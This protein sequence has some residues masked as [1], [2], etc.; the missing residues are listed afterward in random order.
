MMTEQL[1]GRFPGPRRLSIM[2]GLAALALVV[3]VAALAD[4]CTRHPG[5]ATARPEKSTIV[6]GIVPAADAAGLYIAQ[7]RGLFAA[8]NLHVKIVNIL[9][10]ENAVRTQ[11]AGGYDVT[12]GDYVSYIEA[13][14][15]QHAGLR[16]LAEGSV[17]QPGNQ[18]IV[19]L[20]GSRITSLSQ[21]RGAT[22]AVNLRNNIGTI[23]VDEALEDDGISLAAV[24]LVQVP[25]PQMIRALVR[26]EVDAAWMP[27][28]FLSVAEEQIGAR[29]IADLDQGGAASMPVVGYAV[30]RAWEQKYPRT[31]AAFT[32]ALEKAQVIADTERSEVERVTQDFL[33]VPPLT[34]TVMSIPQYPLGVDRVRLQRIADATLQFDMLKERLD[35]SQM[36]SA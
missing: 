21:L 4:G 1:R 19:T 12:I 16:I 29:E 30:T 24:R 15:E 6:V 7:Q 18:V 17:I 20:P 28:P 13:D 10:P 36:T 25:F 26:H 31:A 33:G 27:E 35:V 14:A 2:T 8:A 22:I 3:G 9:S 11:L 34:A 23:L 32:S 5:R